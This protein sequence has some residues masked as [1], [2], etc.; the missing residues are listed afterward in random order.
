[1][2]DMQLL[3]FFLQ[4]NLMAMIRASRYDGLQSSTC[5]KLKGSEKAVNLAVRP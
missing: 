4:A 1:M 2:Q 3:F 5:D